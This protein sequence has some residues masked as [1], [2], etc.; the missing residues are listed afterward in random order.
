MHDRVELE[1]IATVVVDSIYGVHRALGPGLLESAYRACLSYE[2]QR[3]GLLVRG[4]VSFPVHY[5]GLKLAVGYRVDLLV[6]DVII[7]ENKA[8]PALAPIHQAQLLTYLKLAGLKL[9]FLVNWNVPLIKQGLK[10]MVN[11]L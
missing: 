8:V 11:G 6:E 7:V 9:G 1:R 10:R 5:D 3:R 4:E 2:L